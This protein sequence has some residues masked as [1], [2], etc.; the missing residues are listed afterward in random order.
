MLAKNIKNVFFKE[1]CLLCVKKS[2]NLVVL[3]GGLAQ[4]VRALA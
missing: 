4:L 1:I 2:G 3:T